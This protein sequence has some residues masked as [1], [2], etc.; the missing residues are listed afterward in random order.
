M[1]ISSADLTPGIRRVYDVVCLAGE[2]GITCH[3]VAMA[4]SLHY[5]TANKHLV[6]L[7]RAG[8]IEHSGYQYSLMLR[9]P[10]LLWQ[11]TARAS[12]DVDAS[13]PGSSTEEEACR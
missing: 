5:N 9:R 7:Q 2:D 4:L 12:G 3:R 1:T 11:A 6:N 10:S 8:L 13:V